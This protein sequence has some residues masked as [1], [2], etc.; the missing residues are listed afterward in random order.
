[1][2]VDIRRGARIPD[3]KAQRVTFTAIY[4]LK[5]KEK[6]HLYVSKL[7]KVTKLMNNC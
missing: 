4:W 7:D 6:I 3:L 2:S 5:M 1:M